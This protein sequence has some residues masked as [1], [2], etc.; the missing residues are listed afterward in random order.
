MAKRAPRPEHR[1][2]I[3][4]ATADKSVAVQMCKEIEAVGATTF[5]DD[6]DINGATTY[7]RP[8]GRRS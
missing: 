6:R 4:H 3:S 8:S 5:R 1:I 7:R 2:F